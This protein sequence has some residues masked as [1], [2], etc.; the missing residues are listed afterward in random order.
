MRPARLRERWGGVRGDGQRAGPIP[1]EPPALMD[2][3]ETR[4]EMAAGGSA[5]TARPGR[6]APVAGAGGCCD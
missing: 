5:G 3:E 2:A 1:P 6:A 4:V